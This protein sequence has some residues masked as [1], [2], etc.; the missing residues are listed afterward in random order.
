MRQVAAFMMLFPAFGLQGQE[1]K[2]STTFTRDVAP[3]FFKHCASCH[4]P[5]EAGPFPLL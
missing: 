1:T 5:G 2:S 3:L 4:R